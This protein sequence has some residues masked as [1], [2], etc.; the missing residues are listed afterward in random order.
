MS[1]IIKKLL[2]ILGTLISIYISIQTYTQMV[3]DAGQDEYITTTVNL[4]EMVP[5]TTMKFTGS[6]ASASSDYDELVTPTF[7]DTVTGTVRELGLVETGT[8]IQN[9]TIYWAKVYDPTDDTKITTIFV[10][11]PPDDYG[12]F[13]TRVWNRILLNQ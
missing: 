6:I 8:E 7:T 3:V 1:K 11:F 4:G 12:T 10:R 2:G 5:N 9:G 13:A